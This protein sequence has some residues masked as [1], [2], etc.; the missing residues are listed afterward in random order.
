MLFTVHPYRKDPSRMLLRKARRTLVRKKVL[1]VATIVTLA[2]SAGVAYAVGT[3]IWIGTSGHD[4]I[5]L[6]TD[7]NNTHIWGLA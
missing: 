7:T 3:D 2:A 5:N 4:T 6:R 1:V